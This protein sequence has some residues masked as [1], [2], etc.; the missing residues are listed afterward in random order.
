M[1]PD[2]TAGRL[3]PFVI[4]LTIAAAFAV[5]AFF[6]AN[7]LWGQGG[8]DFTSDRA[9][10]RGHVAYVL[11]DADG[12][13]V[14]RWDQ[15]NTVNLEGLDDTFNLI[16]GNGGNGGYDG[17]AA[18][19]VS[20]VTDDPADG[21]LSTSIALLLDGDSGTG[22]NQNPADGVITTD[23][24]SENGNGTVVVTFTAAG[25]VTIAQ[26]VLTRSI[27]D[28]TGDGTLAIADNN[29]FAYIDVPDVSL[30]NGDSVQYTWTIDV[31]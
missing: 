21:V 27:E 9:A 31:D 11:Y 15:H 30:G 3:N 18:M 12:N 22:G 6:T 23:F 2:R 24:G 7:A 20:T 10:L 5:L 13:E 29:I 19:D 1:T 28:E 26:I 14:E 25:S 17:I 8:K 16:T 4:A